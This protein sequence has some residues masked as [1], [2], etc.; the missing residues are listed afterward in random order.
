M[1]YRI[2]QYLKLVV[3]GI[4]LNQ[5]TVGVN[6][7]ETYETDQVMMYGGYARYATGHEPLLVNFYILLSL[8]AEL[9]RCI[10]CF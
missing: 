3:Q 8:Q 9:V 5:Q 2:A 4:L 10:S 7:N 1:A 6:V